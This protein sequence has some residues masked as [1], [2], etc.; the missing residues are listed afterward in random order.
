MVEDKGFSTCLFLVGSFSAFS[1]FYSI[2]VDS[3]SISDS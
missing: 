1:Y 3:M 2:N